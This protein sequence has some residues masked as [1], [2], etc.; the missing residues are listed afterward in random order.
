MIFICKIPDLP[1]PSYY[2]TLNRIVITDLE[3]KFVLQ[4]LKTGKASGPNGLSNRILRKLS[5]ELSHPLCCL[6]NKSLQ[7]GI[8]PASYKEA[9]VCPIHKNGISQM[10]AITD[11]YLY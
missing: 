5:I 9:D 10:S 3:V 1:P 4:T 8:V 2:T 7:S 11:L 6:F